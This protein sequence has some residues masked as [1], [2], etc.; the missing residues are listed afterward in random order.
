MPDD[1]REK[2]LWSLRQGNFHFWPVV[3]PLGPICEVQAEAVQ[4]ALAKAK[5]M[6][7]GK[8]REMLV[9]E[10]VAT[11]LARADPEP[12]L[13]IAAERKERT[14]HRHKIELAGGLVSELARRL[15]RIE[16]RPDLVRQ[17]LVDH[18]D[19]ELGES[20]FAILFGRVVQGQ[21]KGAGQ[22]AFDLLEDSVY[23]PRYRL[24][25]ERRLARSNDGLAEPSTLISCAY[26]GT[27]QTR[28]VG[29]FPNVSVPV[30]ASSGIAMFSMF[31]DAPTNTRYGLSD[32]KIVMIGS[33]TVQSAQDAIKY[34]TA[35]DMRGHFWCRFA[36]GKSKDGGESAD[37]LIAYPEDLTGDKGPLADLVR[38]FGDPDMETQYQEAAAPIFDAIEKLS[39]MRPQALILLTLLRQISNAQV[40]GVYCRAP[41]A[42]AVFESGQA[43]ISA[44]RARPMLVTEGTKRWLVSPA[45]VTRLLG[46][47][48][49]GNPPKSTALAGPSGGDILDFFLSTDTDRAERSFFLLQTLLQRYWSLLVTEGTRSRQERFLPDRKITKPSEGAPPRGRQSASQ[50]DQAAFL[51]AIL[52]DSQGR[53]METSTSS[54]AYRLGLMLGILDTLHIAYHYVVRHEEK[55]TSLAGS[56]LLGIAADDPQRALAELLERMPEWW[57][58][59]RTAEARNEK[60][61][62]PIQRARKAYARLS[63]VAPT[64]E[65]LPNT[66]AETGKSELL[67]GYLSRDGQAD[68]YRPNNEVLEDPN[69]DESSS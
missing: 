32:A 8:G 54:P 57:K 66:L 67:L 38:A 64:I 52:L 1:E 2:S 5:D 56:Q 36:N 16:S 27:M 62:K 65:G 21:I 42:K 4:A 51:L 9:S 18:R 35:G 20:L 12:E 24:D 31:S 47:S 34:V 3:R 60:E 28:H 17:A 39:V 58:W 69:V 61:V 59:A 10:V 30:V 29:K 11:A 33:E 55:P 68:S 44:Q 43:W 15:Q 14:H 63:W 6:R 46:K 40:Q 13:L 7:P 19:D 26:A 49:A 53:S 45:A 41:S 48:W 50:A 37:L 23:D 22:V 25:V